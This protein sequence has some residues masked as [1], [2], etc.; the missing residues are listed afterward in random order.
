MC[1]CEERERG[2]G[3]GGKRAN[4]GEEGG[5]VREE[6][7]RLCSCFCSN[8]TSISVAMVK[9]NKLKKTHYYYIP[10]S[11][12]FAVNLRYFYNIFLY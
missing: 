12:I 3:G 5:T 1:V 10:N 7:G 11:F 6:E 4:G 8:L 9:I 2:R